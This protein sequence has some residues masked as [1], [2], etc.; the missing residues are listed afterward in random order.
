MPIIVQHGDPVSALRLAEMAGREIGAARRR[1]QQR[2]IDAQITQMSIAESFRRNQ[3][4]TFVERA[5]GGGQA[6]A[7]GGGGGRVGSFTQ[8]GRVGS[9]AQ[10]VAAQRLSQERDEK[11][12][13]QKQSERRKGYQAARRKGPESL[14]DFLAE[15]EYATTG[16]GGLPDYM[17]EQFE[18]GGGIQDRIR[19]LP[20]DEESGARAALQGNWFGL[21][22]MLNERQKA[23]AFGE[24][25]D[26]TPRASKVRTGMLTV[27]PD[28]ST[29]ELQA[30]R[31]AVAESGAADMVAAIDQ[32]LE[33]RDQ[34]DIATI[35]QVILPR[36]RRI[37]QEILDA[38]GPPRSTEERLQQEAVY[39]NRLKATVEAQGM[40]ME[41]YMQ[42]YDRMSRDVYNAAQRALTQP[43]LGEQSAPAG[44]EPARPESPAGPATAPAEPQS[45]AARRDEER[46]QNNLVA[47]ERGT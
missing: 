26:L 23:E 11:A 14:A 39:F 16:Q 47:A 29:E 37:Q 38:M 21:S 2:G 40:S 3:R 12:E 13:Q 28:L 43:G 8:G 35:E 36:D 25:G 30:G 20:A 31:A 45:S 24:L 10:T 18:G 41:R 1:E 42:M 27:M 15:E 46:V 17:K 9:D 6:P 4:P 7:G 33:R 5:K 32:E 19:D 22:A 44:G 34:I